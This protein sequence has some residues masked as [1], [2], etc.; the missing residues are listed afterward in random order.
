MS[1]YILH[2]LKEAHETLSAVMSDQ[3]FLSDFE[4]ATNQIVEAFKNNGRVYSCGNGG[5]MCDS[6][7][8][9]EELTGRFRKDRAPLPATA[10]SDP[11]T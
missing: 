11:G 10:I 1:E 7:H 3:S 8:F 2:G 4:K 9:A 6:M 5:S